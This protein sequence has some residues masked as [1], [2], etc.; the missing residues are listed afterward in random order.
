MNPTKTYRLS[1]AGPFTSLSDVS[2]P[3][4][5]YRLIQL[6]VKKGRKLVPWT[7]KIKRDWGCL[8]RRQDESRCSARDQEI[9]QTRVLRL[10][11]RRPLTRTPHLSCPTLYRGRERLTGSRDVT[12]NV[13]NEVN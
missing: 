11:K 12:R 13:G 5:K 7:A 9:R 2:F 6:T 3:F 10:D 8:L 4:S 1:F